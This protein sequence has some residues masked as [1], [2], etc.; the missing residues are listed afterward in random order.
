MAFKTL[1]DLILSVRRKAD[2]ENAGQHVS[3]DE[4]TGYLNSSIAMLWSLLIDG[5]DGSLFAKVSPDLLDIGGADGNSYQLPNDFYKLVE[6]SI[7]RG[8][9]MY[10]ASEADPQE[11]GI[12]LRRPNTGAWDTRYFF[13]YNVEQ[14]RFELFVFPK[15]NATNDI[16]VRYIP[17]APALS[18]G[19]DELK[20][21]SNWDEWVVFDSAIQCLNKEESDPTPLMEEREKRERRLK[22]DI[23]SM[24][25]AT[26]SSIRRFGRINNRR[27]PNIDV[28]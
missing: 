15:P 18:L 11:Y 13:Q 25:P 10:P 1:T 26:V 7:D 19:T 14:G 27:P 17:T 12:L 2:I 22:D 23:R 8:N 4:I 16:F 3:D 24:A 6:L 5:T 28:S 21:P 20:F 9:R